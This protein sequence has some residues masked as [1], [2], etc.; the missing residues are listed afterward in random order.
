MLR[1]RYGMPRIRD[2]FWSILLVSALFLL[3]IASLFIGD[4]GY[5][6]WFVL[7]A[8]LTL[9]YILW[10]FLESFYIEDHVITVKKP[11][12]VSKI[13]IPKTP[14]I[15]MTEAD[16]H[17]KF[18]HQSVAL[19]GRYALTILDEL[20]L[21]AVLERL[22]GQFSSQFKYT[23]STVEHSFQAEFIYSFSFKREGLGRI[24]NTTDCLTIIPESLV[25]LNHLT[26]LPSNVYIDNRC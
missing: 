5:G 6:V 10:P 24:L 11:G 8:V 16:V 20:P 18:G 12:S 17:E 13:V 26:E 19:H 14:V 21:E 3:G 22:F 1:L 7:A 25:R 2:C 4:S 9:V 15:V 23:N